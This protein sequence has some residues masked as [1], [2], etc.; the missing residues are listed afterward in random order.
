MCAWRV[1]TQ[2]ACAPAS[3]QYLRIY[4][5]GGGA[6]PAYLLS[7]GGISSSVL[8]SSNK[9]TFD[10]L[11]LKVVSKSRDVGYLCANFSLPRP[12]CSRVRPDIRD[13]QTSDRQTDRHTDVRRQT[14][15]RQKHILMPPPYRGGGI[16]MLRNVTICS[17]HDRPR[18][19]P[20]CSSRNV[21][22]TASR[23][24]FNIIR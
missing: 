4:S 2:Y 21:A 23:S 9:L 20:A 6:V 5:P 24:R 8:A 10:L 16:I 3:W 12:L 18:R 7:P 22:S 14:D 15:V 19:M 1:A 17:V 13:S 11:T